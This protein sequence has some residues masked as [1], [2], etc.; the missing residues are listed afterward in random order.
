[1]FKYV[2]NIIRLSRI[3]YKLFTILSIAHSV[4]Y[5]YF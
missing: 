2:T 4:I 3:E 1:M 5:H